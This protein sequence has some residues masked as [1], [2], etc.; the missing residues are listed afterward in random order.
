MPGPKVD[1]DD[2]V[3]DDDG[4]E[5]GIRSPGRTNVISLRRLRLGGMLWI[6]FGRSR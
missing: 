6:S 5:E 2:D 1:D 4:A 3:V